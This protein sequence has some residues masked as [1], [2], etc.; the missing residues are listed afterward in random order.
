MSRTRGYIT[1]GIV[2]ALA[3]GGC[4]RDTAPEVPADTLGPP[5]VTT[6]DGPQTLP[7]MRDASL[8]WE[9]IQE[10][11]LAADA[12]GDEQWLD[13]PMP[14][15][16]PGW[17]ADAFNVD[18]D[19]FVQWGVHDGRDVL[20]LESYPYYHHLL[21]REGDHF[22]VVTMASATTVMDDLTLGRQDQW[23]HLEAAGLALD[24]DTVYFTLTLP[25]DIDFETLSMV[26]PWTTADFTATVRLWAAGSTLRIG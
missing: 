14:T 17:V 9:Q 18:T 24:H 19:S 25:R 26:G 15:E 7:H 4:T 5:A 22:T 12:S 16:V 20:H 21:E 1:G 3:F 10:L 8:T 11:A 13:A 2:I 6:P 23:E